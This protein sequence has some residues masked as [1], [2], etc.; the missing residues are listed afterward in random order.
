MTEHLPDGSRLSYGVAT[1]AY[2]IEGAS[3][4]DGRGPSIWDTF[5]ARPGA[6]RDG[7]DGSVAC[8]SYHRY[9]EDLD[10]VA[11]SGVQWYRFSVAWP[12]IVPAGTGRVESRGLDYYDRLVDAALAR[13]I[14]PTATL[15]HW[16]LPQALED[17]DGWLNRDTAEA[18]ADYASVVHDRLGDRVQVWATH[19]EPWCAAYLGYSAGV[20]APGRKEGG[21]GHRAAHHLNLAHGLA[22]ARLHEAGVTDLG[23]V[24]NLAPYWPETPE[25]A[26][27]AD[28]LDALRNRVWLG[29]LVDGAYDEG[30]LRVA[31]E[32]ADEGLVRDGDLALVRGSA[33]WIGV[34][35]YT[36]FRPTLADP[37]LER[38]PEVEAYPGAT[39][40]SFVV[41]EPRT[42]IGWEV[43]AS[44]LEELL[45]DTHKRTGL[46][47]LVT[48]NGAAYPDRTLDDQDRVGYLRE[49][50]A[51]TERARAAGADVRAY[52]VWTLLD[53]FE[54]AEGYTKTF[55][56]VHIDPKDLTRTPKAS[57]RW[58]AAHVA[59]S[60]APGSGPTA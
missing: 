42:D 25:A 27:A 20:H 9:A 15:Y 39:P 2:Q 5:A 58:L 54:W 29:P 60:R 57:Y 13:G 41:R 12:R 59:S 19:N 4:E 46:P 7:R 40:V 21:A 37:A 51:A 22:A 31:P 52:I 53:N 30:L 16:D 28:E 26:G 6:T 3:T 36:P 1:A 50:I 56:I 43:D 10:L 11:G 24:H 8:D 48:E 45:V 32:L 49:H 33:D 47:V 38:H 44:G 34:N 14:S 35:Y 17:R 18:F 55:G 23:I